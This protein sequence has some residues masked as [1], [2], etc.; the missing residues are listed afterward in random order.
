MTSSTQT[1]NCIHCGKSVSPQHT[2]PCPNCGK[3]GKMIKV[4]VTETLKIID[5]VSLTKTSRREQITK[6]PRGLILG[7]ILFVLGIIINSIDHPF[8]FVIGI[9]VG[10][11]GVA[12]TP[13]NVKVI[14]ESTERHSN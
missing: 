9:I 5:K 3:T 14:T 12:L 10:I 1:A 6:R 8:S 7:I 11:N 13:I 2:G 4:S